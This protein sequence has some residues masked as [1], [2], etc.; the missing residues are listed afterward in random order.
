MCIENKQLW[1][2]G[3]N[4][5]RV[6]IEIETGV[7]RE[8]SGKIGKKCAEED[9]TMRDSNVDCCMYEVVAVIHSDEAMRESI[10]NA[11]HRLGQPSVGLSS[12]EEFVCCKEAV[13]A[14]LLDSEMLSRGEGATIEKLRNR[15]GNTA[16]IIIN[17]EVFTHSVGGTLGALVDK[18]RTVLRMVT[19]HRTTNSAVVS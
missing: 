12:A 17:R 1:N 15:A 14:V 9:R 19:F 13:G 5:R 18:L 10:I 7:V 4:W 6:C 2:L 11:L 8:E 3:A 16:P